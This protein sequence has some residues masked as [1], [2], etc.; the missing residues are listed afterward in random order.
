MSIL[1]VINLKKYY[2]QNSNITKALDSVTLYIE[3]GEFI[4][5]VGTSGSGKSTL[6]NMMGGLDNPTSGKVIIKG[7]ELSTM[8]DE[9][10]TIFRRRNIGFIFQ[11]YNLVPLLNV[12]ENIILPI[13][14]DGE[15]IDKDFINEIIN[16]LSLEEKLYD[17]PSNLSGGQQQR[18]AIARALATKPAIILADEPTGN[19]DSRTSSDVLSLLKVTSKKFNQTIV[20]ITHNNEIA[21]LTDRIIR[22]EDGKIVN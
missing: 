8:T 1:Q 2:G 7:K 12:Y 15:T 5:I 6:L 20:M 17:M 21:Q 22:I 3:K 11:N 10:L 13:G 14:L 19:L 4:S 9:Q 18:V 16:M